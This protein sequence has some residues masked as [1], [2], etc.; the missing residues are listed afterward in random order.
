MLLL[1]FVDFCFFHFLQDV[2]SVKSESDL[3]EVDMEVH[4]S[5]NAN[6]VEL[7]FDSLSLCH[8]ITAVF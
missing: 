2:P 6:F 7:I 8:T 1:G 5:S 3:L 4:L